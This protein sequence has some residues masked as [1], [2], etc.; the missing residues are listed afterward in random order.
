MHH[1]NIDIQRLAGTLASVSRNGAEIRI[2]IFGGGIGGLCMLE[3]LRHFD[4]V[5]VVGIVDT[6][7]DAPAFTLAKELGI[8]T[9]CDSE[10]ALAGFDGDILIDVTG[11]AELHKRLHAFSKPQHLELISGK[12]AKLLFDLANHQLIDEQTI[13]KQQRRMNLLEQPAGDHHAARATG[14]ARSCHQ[15]LA[16]GHP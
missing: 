12:S 2:L 3:T 14:T 8:P 13:E 5:E 9:A 10:A 1:D 7:A 15:P 6:L 11:D 16:A 4:G